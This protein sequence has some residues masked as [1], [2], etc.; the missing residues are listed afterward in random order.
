MCI[1]S[2]QSLTGLGALFIRGLAKDG[3]PIALAQ[4]DISRH[5]PQPKRA[6]AQAG[7]EVEAVGVDGPSVRYRGRK[8]AL[9]RRIGAIAAKAGAVFSGSAVKAARL[10][11]VAKCQVAPL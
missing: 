9:G 8:V 7:V 11:A 3:W 2:P 4:F 1:P 6:R 5:I 10:A